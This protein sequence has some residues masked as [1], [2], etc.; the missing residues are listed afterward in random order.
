MRF[1]ILASVMSL[2]PMLT[3]GQ[4]KFRSVDT[5]KPI[6]FTF[7]FHPAKGAFVWYK[8][9]KDPIAL[10][11]KSLDIDSS[12][13]EIGQP[14]FHFYKYSEVYQGKVTGE[15]GITEWPRNVDDIYYIRF[16]DAKKFRFELIKDDEFYSGKSMV[17]LKGVQIHF[18]AFY[19]N[20][21]TFIY[22]NGKNIKHRLTQLDKSQARRVEIKDYNFDGVDDISFETARGGGPNHSFDVF[23]YN[24][25]NKT[26]NKLVEPATGCG[27]FENLKVDQINKRLVTICKK[28]TRETS[29]SYKFNPSGNLL[30]VKPE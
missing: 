13:R 19:Y 18:N 3:F 15:Y 22:P 9:Q 4:M 16:K 5:P 11:L 26:F 29:F 12:E 6:E 17:L 10:K 23:I 27:G 8:G 7:G 20:N 21:V 2:M 30:L 1:K 24:P 28:E 14:D 25:A